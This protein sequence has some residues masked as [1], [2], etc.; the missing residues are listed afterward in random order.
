MRLSISGPLAPMTHYQYGL[1]ENYFKIA[2]EFYLHENVVKKSMTF[3]NRN[4]NK[5][6]WQF[7]IKQNLLGIL[8]FRFYILITWYDN[9][10]EYFF[11]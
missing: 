7:L 9:C 11:I 3:I 2:F 4:P 1:S 8:H 10:T 5:A 6:I